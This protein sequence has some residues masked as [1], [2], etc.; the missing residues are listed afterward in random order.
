MVKKSNI[1]IEIDNLAVKDFFANSDLLDYIVLRPLSHI[2]LSWE[3]VWND[4][5]KEY[6][7]EEDT[8]AGLLN[9]LIIE[10]SHTIPPAKYHNNEDT[11][12]EYVKKRLKWPIYKVGNRWKGRNYESILEAGGFEDINEKDLIEAATGRIIAAIKYGQSHFDEME[13][14]HK[15]IL[16]LV[17]TIIIYHRVN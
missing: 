16:A 2:N 7:R 8:F 9:D 3:L 11:L 5:K 10:L 15:K 12:A 1:T 4:V 17:L 14:S 6:Y 13:E